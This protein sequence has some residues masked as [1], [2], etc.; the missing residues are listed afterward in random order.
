M[1]VTYPLSLPS[2]PGFAALDVLRPV[3]VV[4]SNMS[5]YTLSQQVQ[6]YQGQRWEFSTPLPPMDIADSSEWEAF[7]LNLNGTEGTF[8]MG[9]P[10]RPTPRGSAAVAPGT[11]VIDGA[12]QTGYDINIDGLP[13]SVAGYLLKGD[14]VQFGTAATARLYK[15]KANANSDGT[16]KAVLSLWPRVFTPPMDGSAVVVSG[17]KGVFRLSENKGWSAQAGIFFS[18]TLSGYS[19]P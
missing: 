3:A 9:D 19:I 14:L 15:L 10:T 7:F 2:S 12:G 17:A 18:H 1:A 11:P 4:G 13:L 8:L 6:A 5:P 16:G